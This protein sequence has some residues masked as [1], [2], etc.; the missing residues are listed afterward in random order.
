MKKMIGFFLIIALLIGASVLNG[1]NNEIISSYNKIAI[2]SS[3]YVK[4]Y[5]DNAIESGGKYYYFF[6]NV[7]LIDYEKFGN[8]E[9][10]NFYFDKITP[11]SFFEDNVDFIYKSDGKVNGY[12]IYYGYTVKYKD[13]LNIN[14]KKI[15]FQLVNT[16]DEWIMGF[17][18][19]LTG[20]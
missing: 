17:P 12:D 8:I 3:N 1:V 7:S 4:D 19:I 15:N 2:V 16:Q 11:F 9:G 5:K 18:L 13:F 6:D 10:L 20:F 14:N